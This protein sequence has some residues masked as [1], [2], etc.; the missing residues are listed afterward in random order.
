MKKNYVFIGTALIIVLAIGAVVFSQLPKNENKELLVATIQSSLESL[1]TISAHVDAKAAEH[2]KEEGSQ[3]TINQA[4]LAIETNR[5]RIE[6]QLRAFRKNSVVKNNQKVPVKQLESVQDEITA[7]WEAF[8]RLSEP[9]IYMAND[10]EYS[11]DYASAVASFKTSSQDV[12]SKLQ[13]LLSSFE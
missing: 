4:I 6:T 13:K 9:L 3:E 2:Q 5:M 8:S 12:T 10:S 11:D 7:L 1:E